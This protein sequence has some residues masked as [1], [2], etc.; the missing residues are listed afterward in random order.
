MEGCPCCGYATLPERGG[1]DI[2]AIC[3]WEDDGQDNA[4]AD[5]DRGGPNALSLTAGRRNFLLG[6]VA[7]PQDRPHVRPPGPVDRKLRTFEIRGDSVA[8]LPPEK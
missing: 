5:N 3:F 1:Y 4:D 2:C 7:D 6:G 8:E